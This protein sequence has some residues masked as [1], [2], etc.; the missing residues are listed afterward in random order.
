MIACRSN[1]K[2]EASGDKG[3]SIGQITVIPL[4]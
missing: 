2:A 3:P 1:P 4:A